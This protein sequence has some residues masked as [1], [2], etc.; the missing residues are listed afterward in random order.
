MNGAVWSLGVVCRHGSTWGE[1]PTKRCNDTNWMNAKHADRPDSWDCVA[2]LLVWLAAQSACSGSQAWTAHEEHSLARVVQGYSSEQACNRTLLP[3][4]MNCWYL[5]SLNIAFAWPFQINWHL[6]NLPYTVSTI[7]QDA[8]S[9]EF[10]SFLIR[11]LFSVHVKLLILKI[12]FQ[13]ECIL[14]CMCCT[15]LC[16]SCSANSWS[17]LMQ[18]FISCPSISVIWRPR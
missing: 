4:F 13:C 16:T 5:A 9:C 10:R 15:H 17:S 11:H 14:Q 18:A 2:A 6:W 1:W 8:R 12:R 7:G 3:L